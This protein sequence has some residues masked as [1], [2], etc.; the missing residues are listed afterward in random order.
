[1]GKCGKGN[2]RKG[3]G[4]VGLIADGSARVFRLAEPVLHEGV[5]FGHAIPLQHGDSRAAGW[6]AGGVLGDKMRS[7]RFVTAFV[8]NDVRIDLTS[9]GGGVRPGEGGHF[10]RRSDLEF[11]IQRSTERRRRCGDVAGLMQE[12]SRP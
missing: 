5:G 6:Q 11:V 12:V 9:E 1:M 2:L 4:P 8:E 3:G 7:V 10:I